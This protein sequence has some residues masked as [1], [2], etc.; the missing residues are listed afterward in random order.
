MYYMREKN[1]GVRD[2]LSEHA[3]R[4]KPLVSP[5]S[6]WA[7][8]IA[9]LLPRLED[10]KNADAERI[11]EIVAHMP[12]EI[13][14]NELAKAPGFTYG[15][16]FETEPPPYYKDG[17]KPVTAPLS[18]EEMNLLLYGSVPAPMLP[19]VLRHFVFGYH[20][21]DFIRDA[22]EK[23]MSDDSTGTVVYVSGEGADRKINVVF[24]WASFFSE[25][26]DPE[27][28][29]MPSGIDRGRWMSG[30]IDPSKINL[31]LGRIMA[32]MVDPPWAGNETDSPD[33]WQ[34]L[35]PPGFRVT[36][37]RGEEGG[38]PTPDDLWADFVSLAFASP[39]EAQR[40]AP[41]LY[42]YFMKKAD[43][44]TDIDT[45]DIA[46]DKMEERRGSSRFHDFKIVYDLRTP[47]EKRKAEEGGMSLELAW[48]DRI[49]TW[50]NRWPL[51]LFGKKIV[52]SMPEDPERAYQRE[53]DKGEIAKLLEQT[54]CVDRDKLFGEVLQQAEGQHGFHLRELRTRARQILI[55]NSQSSDFAEWR[56]IAYLHRF[57]EKFRH[58]GGYEISKED[59]EDLRT[60]Y[61]ESG[62]AKRIG[63]D[64]MPYQAYQIKNKDLPGSRWRYFLTP[65]AAYIESIR[66]KVAE[67]SDD[68]INK[69]AIDG[70]DQ[71]MDRF[72]NL[73]D[74]DGTFNSFTD[75]GMEVTYGNLADPEL[76]GPD[77]AYDITRL[78]LEP[79]KI[80]LIAPDV[81]ETLRRSREY[82]IKR[83]GQ[84]D[85]AMSAQAQRFVA[86]YNTQLD[87]PAHVLIEKLKLISPEHLVRAGNVDM[88]A[89]QISESNTVT[90]TTLS[91]IKQLV[92]LKDKNGNSYYGIELV[93][94]ELL[95][96]LA[97]GATDRAKLVSQL[98]NVARTKTSEPEL[99]RQE[100]S[101]L[102]HF[103]YGLPK[104][105]ENIHILQDAAD[106]RRRLEPRFARSI[107]TTSK[108]LAENPE[109]ILTGRSDAQIEK[110]LTILDKAGITKKEDREKAGLAEAEP[111]SLTAAT[112]ITREIED[113]GIREAK[114]DQLVKKLKPIAEKE[115]LGKLEE[116]EKET[117]L[118]ELAQIIASP[119][120][121]VRP[122]RI[123]DDD[124]RTAEHALEDVVAGMRQAWETEI[125]TKLASATADQ[126][127]AVVF[128]LIERVLTGGTNNP[129]SLQSYLATASDPS[130]C[131]TQLQAWFSGPGRI[132]DS[133]GMREVKE[134]LQA[135]VA[136]IA[137]DTVAGL[138]TQRAVT[139]QLTDAIAYLKALA[140][141]GKAPEKK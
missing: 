56:V 23:I 135:V 51:R 33:D 14:P 137:S 76:L 24:N 120:G 19:F 36:K 12:E 128:E 27:D 73:V 5:T 81:K 87:R 37:G 35:F 8:R 125:K 41:E 100:E 96:A 105:Q 60:V 63:S 2:V 99:L 17:E 39:D 141:E 91:A 68:A 75:T 22:N 109:F 9:T 31:I 134:T 25:I 66:G 47:D 92:N 115:F 52:F 83:K 131:S 11:E 15:R 44:F 13:D 48:Y 127:Q 71:C 132:F 104:V 77:L 62:K 88:I 26:T 138:G 54:R 78:Y 93:P 122:G 111:Q 45:Q 123:S 70:F 29:Q 80:D 6:S 133:P 103:L 10:R 95:A 3:L 106:Y 30:R 42:Q 110:N 107:Q 85:K 124:R 116:A 43:E 16:G 108:D 28:Y 121:V 117:A 32:Q 136:Q 79:W 21:E 72:G 98:M 102:I 89:K 61:N 55:A 50:L 101:N 126:R 49:A 118:T 82:I 74:F 57:S 64:M 65:R 114:Q 112:Y 67:Y 40:A 90:I 1:I 7:E 119:D 130:Q 58:S 18:Q 20:E 113:T 46:L 4:E 84:V 86:A 97:A 139:D 129:D 59:Y 34:K 140:A 53:K 69:V 38:P 94:E